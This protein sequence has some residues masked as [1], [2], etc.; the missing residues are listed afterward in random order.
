M[1]AKTVIF[2]LDDTLYPELDF[3]KS[4]F[5]AV[6]DFLSRRYNV[7]KLRIERRMSDILRKKG[8]GKIFD[9]VLKEYNLYSKDMVNVLIFLYRSHT[10]ILK[11]D[12]E[13][14]SV[15]MNLK[16]RGK[17]LGIITDG[18]SSVQRNKA[19]ALK[20]EKYFNVVL[21]TD[22]LGREYWKPSSIPFMAAMNLLSSKPEETV[23]VGNDPGKDFL[24]ANLLGIA[25]IQ[26]NGY[27]S[28]A[29]KRYVK[30]VAAPNICVRRISE[31]L[32]IVLS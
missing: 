28:I 10:P 14:V 1:M 19:R 20:L 12:K 5:R 32:P 7:D 18:L 31:I 13:V 16:K 27:S 29:P 15:L 24:G 6:A 22:E 23:Y 21:C 8:R 4:G 25:T 30:P 2:D 9:T 3:V 17:A 11:L 26:V